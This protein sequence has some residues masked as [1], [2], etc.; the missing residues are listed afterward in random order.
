[1][2]VKYKQFNTLRKGDSLFVIG[3]FPLFLQEYEVTNILYEN[4]GMLV[5]VGNPK[6]EHVS[7]MEGM[8]NFSI[9]GVPMN[10]T[11]LELEYSGNQFCISCDREALMDRFQ[12]SL[13]DTFVN[14]ERVKAVLNNWMAECQNRIEVQ[15]NQIIKLCSQ[16]F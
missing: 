16:Q 14:V 2:D 7:S 4:G 1:M 8:E 12:E 6:F 15:R 9:K 10:D 11:L 3:K 13:I 5:S